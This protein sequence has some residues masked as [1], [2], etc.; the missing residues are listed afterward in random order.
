MQ[1]NTKQILTTI[2]QSAII[3]LISLTAGQ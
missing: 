2:Y 1:K 3:K